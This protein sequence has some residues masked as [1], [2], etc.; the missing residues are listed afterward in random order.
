M[1]KDN[2]F[3][4]FKLTGVVREGEPIWEWGTMPHYSAPRMAQR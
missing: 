1:T 4:G 3:D 2:L